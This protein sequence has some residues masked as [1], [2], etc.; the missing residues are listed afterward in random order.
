MKLNL[1]TNKLIVI[2]GPTAIGKTKLAVSIAKMY[3]TDIISADSRQMFKELCIG[4]DKPSKKQL[5]Q[6]NHHFVNYIS[7]T[8]DYSVGKYEKDCKNLLTKLFKKSNI[9]IM[10]G[11]SGLYLESICGGLNTFPEI[12]KETKQKVSNWYQNKGMEFLKKKLK[13][14]DTDSYN[15]IDIKNPRRVIRA[16]E[17]CMS[18]SS[19]FSDLK[20]P[21]KFE[22]P[23][24]ILKICLTDERENIYKRIDNRV[25][26]MIESGL[27]DEAKAMYKYRNL[28]SLQTIGYKEFFE[29]F[30]GKRSKI[31][32][33]NEIK[34]NSRRYAKRQITWFKGHGYLQIDINNLNT[35]NEQIQRFTLNH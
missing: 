19:K 27:L 24:D 22:R 29:Y 26:K 2:A 12:K 31:E 8:D 18:S 4:V 16:L 9:Q 13:K 15:S 25:D 35:I 20:Q 14:L 6:I 23:F 34:K 28:K 10:C 3:K 7:I 5:S 17:V 21:M 33:I 1:K 30:E 32:A 11:G